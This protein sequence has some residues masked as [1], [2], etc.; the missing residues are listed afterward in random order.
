MAQQSTSSKIWII[1]LILFG[2]F[3]ISIF[4]AMIFSLAL[5]GTSLPAT[6][7]VALVPIVGEITTDGSET[8]WGETTTSSTDVVAF[9]EEIEEDDSIKA[10]LFEIDSPGGS[11]VASKE[12]VDAIKAAKKP[13]VAVIRELGASGAYWAASAADHIIADELSITGSIGVLSSYLEF[14]GLMERYG[15]KYQEITGGKYKDTGSPFKNLTDEERAILQQKIDKIHRIFIDSVA[16]NRN[17]SRGQ[18]LKAADGM[19]L[20]GIEAKELGLV[21]EIGNKKTAEAW[22]KQKTNLT[23]I[24]YVE[25]KYEPTLLEALAKLKNQNSF[26]IG[27]GIASYFAEQKNK[28]RT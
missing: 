28:I 8:V 4:T 22:I 18:V 19:F 25:Y 9:I 3:I 12:I 13:K 7:N 6:G 2:L 17:L 16:Q 23:E 1:V 11:A 5:F 26:F 27:K 10:I 24:S 21:D 15:V 14:S 20:L